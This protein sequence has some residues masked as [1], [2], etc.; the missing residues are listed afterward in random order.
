MKNVDK[1]FEFYY[2]NLSNRRKFIRTLWLGPF[3]LIIPFLLYSINVQNSINIIVSIL[4][5]ATWL[6][7]SV[8]TYKNIK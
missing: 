5:F 6:V 3:V 4:A 1:G 2:H 8:I 7:Q